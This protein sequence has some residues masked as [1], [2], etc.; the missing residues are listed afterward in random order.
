M[1]Y[2]A[3][4]TFGYQPSKAILPQC[5]F[6]KMENSQKIPLSISSLSND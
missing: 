3:M 4:K 6:K 5:F 1:E 2:V